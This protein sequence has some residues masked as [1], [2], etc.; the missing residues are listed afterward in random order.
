MRPHLILL[1]AGLIS[2]A[3]AATTWNKPGASGEDY[4]DAKLKCTAQ[5]H[6]DCGEDDGQ[7]GT[8]IGLAICRNRIF[9][10]CL[11]QRGWAPK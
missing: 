8:A 2:S 4:A 10:E 11:H 9:G 5:A 1:L 3:C 7:S 6:L